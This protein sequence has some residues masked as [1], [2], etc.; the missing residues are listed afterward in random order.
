M[1]VKKEIH[2]IIFDEEEKLIRVFC[3]VID[4]SICYA[5]ENNYNS[6]D[7]YIYVYDKIDELLVHVL[8]YYGYDSKDNYVLSQSFIERI[9]DYIEPLFLEA[10]EELRNKALRLFDISYLGHF[11]D[12]FEQF[13]KIISKFD[14]RNMSSAYE[15]IKIRRLVNDDEK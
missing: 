7:T 15:C 4:E 1:D 13:K 12:E 10:S 6:I 8:N 2:D 9:Y 11:I 3:R 14:E 5:K